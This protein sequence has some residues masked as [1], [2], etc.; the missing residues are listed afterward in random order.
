MEGVKKIAFGSY[1][2]TEA[3]FRKQQV[4]KAENWLIQIAY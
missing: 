3:A 2:Q 1:D 4:Y